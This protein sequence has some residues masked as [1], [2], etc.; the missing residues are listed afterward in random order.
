MRKILGRLFSTGQVLFEGQ[1]LYSVIR[2]VKKGSQINL[3]TG[4]GFLQSSLNRQE[5]PHGTIFDWYLVAPWFSGG[6]KGT[7]DSLL[8]LGLGAG[9]QVALYNR[10][11]KV[12]S[13]T[14]VE[15]DPLIIDLGKK[16]FDLNDA[17]LKTICGDACFFL[18]T[19]RDFYDLIIL[20]LFK[21]DVFEGSCQSNSFFHQAR[22]H[23]TSEGVLLVNR[24]LNDLFNSE[25]ESE[26]KKIFNTVLTLRI[27]RNVFVIST[28]SRNS[29][30]S[31]IEIQQLLLK[32]SK[33]YHALS[34]F[35]SLK[36][37]DI[38]VL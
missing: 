37:K 9:S 29:P 24:V 28:N 14:G 8:I 27:Y 7:F 33:S 11:Y 34:F 30:K 10:F 2:V 6:F 32:A 15:V 22:G 21:E 20:D 18:D 35:R 1:G 13:I 17:N 25:M 19:A 31:S 23:L 3:Y 16:Y 26:L 12:R 5:I 38:K 4:R 36:L